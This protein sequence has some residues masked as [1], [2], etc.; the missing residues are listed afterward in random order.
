INGAREQFKAAADLSPL[1]SSFK[2]TYAEYLAR[3]GASAEATTYLQTLTKKTPD[4]LPAWTLL[5]RTTLSGKKPDETLA[6][7]ENVFSRDPDNVDAR[8]L[9]AEALL[10]KQQIKKAVDVLE[11]L[12]RGHPSAPGI[13]LQLAKAYLQESHPDQAAAALKQAITANPDFVEAILLLAKIDLQAGQTGQAIASLEELLKKRGNLGRAQILLA[14]AYHAAGRLEDAARIFRAQIAQSPKNSE[15]Y[16]F[17]GLIQ[18][19]QNK[20]EEARQSFEKARELNPA[21]LIALSKLIDLDL[22]AN[23]F[24]SASRRAEEQLSKEPKAGSSHLLKGKVLTA[25]KQWP[26]AEVTLKKAV[27][28]DPN[29]SSAYDLLVAIYLETGKSD[30]ALRELEAVLAHAPQNKGALM[31]LASVEEKQGNFAKAADAY[32]RLLSFDPNDATAL[33]NLAYIYAERLNQIDKGLDLARKARTQ[34]PANAAVADT[35]GWVLFKRDDYRE[36]LPLLEEAAAKISDSPEVKF[37]AGMAHYMMGQS[38]AARSYFQQALAMKKDFPSRKEAEQRLQL[39]DQTTAGSAGLTA[40]QLESLLKQNPNDIVVRLRLA[41]VYKNN[42]SFA[43]AAA[44]YG[45]ALKSNPKLVEAALRLAELYAGPLKDSKKALEFAKKARELAP[46]DPQAAGVLGRIAYEAGNFQWAYSLLQESSRQAGANPGVLH[47][48]AWAAYSLGKVEQARQAMQ[49]SL[50][51]GPAPEVAADGKA[52]LLLTAAP[53]DPAAT[54]EIEQ[55][56]KESPPYIP[57]LMAAAAADARAGQPEKA[58]EKYQAVLQK[59]PE[60]SPAQK[61]LALLYAQDSARSQEA[62][63]LALQARKSLPSDASLAK[64]LGR[65]SYEKKEYSR[66]QQLLQESA[67]KEPLDPEGLYYLG[68][69]YKETKQRGEAEKALGGAL[70]AGLPQPLDENARK[71]L[72]E[73]KKR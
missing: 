73:L 26:E 7:L 65:L 45:Q 14:D 37:H 20:P 3:T 43:Q 67:R 60:F 17:L 69:S 55:R 12:S 35:L 54:S 44:A 16:T 34:A 42:Q 32:Q 63:S 8:L 49:Q 11:L 6:L 71:A 30:R 5:A 25:K 56:L 15:A 40:E 50:D 59:F 21:D 13:K 10:E 72:A 22:E 68:L 70:A 53:I 36:A 23:N 41:E 24:E 61:E 62:Y 9:Q 48:L 1:R 33:N 64:L 31:T 27:E 47:D 38:D 19:Q 66:A 51:A 18:Q 29:L 28:L 2:I 58:V 46:S 52:F 4:F 39:L 57:A